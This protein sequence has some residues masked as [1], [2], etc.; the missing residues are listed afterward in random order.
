VWDNACRECHGDPHTGS[1]RITEK[2]SLVPDDSAAL[3]K[4]LAQQQNAS[5][6]TTTQLIV[7][8]KI[9]HGEFFGV[10]G[11]MPPFSQEQMS[12]DDIGAL[13]S[14]LDL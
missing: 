11:I 8:E 9:R 10:G 12:D 7:I 2:A 3:A 14:F 6:A 1:G 5:V 13:L 4:V